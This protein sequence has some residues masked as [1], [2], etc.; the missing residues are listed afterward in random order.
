LSIAK[1]SGIK[2]EL[3]LEWINHIDLCR[4]K[5]VAAEF[6]DLLEEA[7][8]DT[9][10]ELSNRNPARLH[11]K[12]SSVNEAKKLVRQLPSLEQVQDWIEQARLLPRAI[13]Y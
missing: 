13:S 8:V 3:I 12:L 7:G 9:V 1:Q 2:E 6:A 11:E 10:V 4:I 5:G